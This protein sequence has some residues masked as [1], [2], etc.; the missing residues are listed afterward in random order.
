MENKYLTPF[1]DSTIMVLETMAFVK[2]VVGE[3]CLWNKEKTVA[4]VVG[5]IGFSNKEENIKGFMSIGFTKSSIIQIVS[6]MLGEEFETMND[7]VREA[8][9]DLA[10]MIS[11]QA[12]QKTSLMGNKLERGLPLLFQGKTLR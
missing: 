8:A 5:L 12:R 10:N 6:N 7:E 4:E 1:I 9:G 3:T 11:C 2:P